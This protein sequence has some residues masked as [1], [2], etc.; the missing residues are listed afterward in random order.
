MS[1]DDDANVCARF[2][3]RFVEEV[4]N[5]LRTCMVELLRTIILY[6]NEERWFLC[7]IITAIL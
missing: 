7:Y 5:K 2:N 6:I 1:T 3:N 4:E